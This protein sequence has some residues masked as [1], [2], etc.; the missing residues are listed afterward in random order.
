MELPQRL[1][2]RAPSAQDPSQEEIR[3]GRER[4]GL[5]PRVLALLDHSL[6]VLPEDLYVLE[7]HPLKFVTPIGSLRHLLHPLKRKGEV[8]ALDLRSK[9][10]RSAEVPVGE[11]L[12]LP[13]AQLFSTNSLDE[14]FHLVSLDPAASHELTERVHVGV[15]RE[16]SAEDLLPHPLRHLREE[17]QTYSDPGLAPGERL[18]DVRDRHSVERPQI[19]DEPRLFEDA[20][21][22][23][24]RC[25]QDRYDPCRLI[26]SQRGVGHQGE[27]Q[28]ACTAVA[29]EAVEEDP[30]LRDIDSFQRLLDATLRNRGKQS[31]L[32]RRILHPVALV[33][34]VKR[35][36]LGVFHHHWHHLGRIFLQSAHNVVDPSLPCEAALS[37]CPPEHLEDLIPAH[38]SAL[39]ETR[40]H[41]HVLEDA[42]IEL[43]AVEL[44]SGGLLHP[45]LVVI[46]LR[47]AATPLCVLELLL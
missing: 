45:L 28:L 31:P 7:E 35:F 1:R 2:E 6:H 24:V 29:L 17:P 4:P 27:I 5:D 18:G 11:V 19:I 46:R 36:E 20:E 10:L 41:P 26:F 15:D 42:R 47:P 32:E 16:R 21:A 23:V 25:S 30:L 38:S 8:A 37:H 34:Q 39:D 3:L 44:R 22:F 40:H 14:D 13:D 9:P 12:D 33:A 43:E